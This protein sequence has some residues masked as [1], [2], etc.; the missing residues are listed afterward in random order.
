[1]E[2]WLRPS[3]DRWTHGSSGPEQRHPRDQIDLRGCRL[4]VGRRRVARAC[5]RVSR[6]AVAPAV[7]AA[8]PRWRRASRFCSMRWARLCF[9]AASWAWRSAAC[10]PHVPIV[11]HGVVAVDVIRRCDMSVL[12]SE[13][14]RGQ[15]PMRSCRTEPRRSGLGGRAAGGRRR[16]AVSQGR[17][18]R[19]SIR[20]DRQ[21][22]VR[23]E[24]SRAHNAPTRS[25]GWAQDHLTNTSSN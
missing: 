17:E 15:D 6:Q 24:P 12:L 11:G 23:G 13:W 5:C 25:G 3:P 2:R 7:T 1:M 16:I 19:R 18:K 21:R 10:R 8:C 4:V 14:F 22:G 20:R 9:T